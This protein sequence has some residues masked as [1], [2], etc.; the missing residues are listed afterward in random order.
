M[1]WDINYIGAGGIVG[2]I[3]NYKNKVEFEKEIKEC[4]NSGIPI[5]FKYANNEEEL[6]R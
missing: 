5:T 2:E 4:F 6:E 3:I 1:K